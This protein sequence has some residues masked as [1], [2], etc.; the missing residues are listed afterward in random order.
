VAAAKL[1][2]L[3]DCVQQIQRAQTALRHALDCE[4]DRLDDCSVHHRILRAHAEA[5]AAAAHTTSQGPRRPER[6]G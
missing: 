6:R 2:E 1:R 5:L 4:R 3:D